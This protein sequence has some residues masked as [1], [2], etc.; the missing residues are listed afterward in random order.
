MLTRRLTALAIVA[1]FMVHIA[2]V[3]PAAEWLNRQASTEDN[4]GLEIRPAP[5]EMI[6]PLA[7]WLLPDN[8][9]H[10]LEEANDDARK[11]ES[12]LGFVRTTQNQESLV[13]PTNPSFLSD[14]NT[15]L[16]SPD[17][18][19]EDP[20]ELP[21]VD[22]DEEDTTDLERRSF[23]DGPVLEESPSPINPEPRPKTMPPT[24]V[25]QRP[26]PEQTEAKETGT[27]SQPLLELAQAIPLPQPQPGGNLG[28]PNEL[29]EYPANAQDQPGE[30]KQET[31]LPADPSE[32]MPTAQEGPQTPAHPLTPPPAPSTVPM[33]DRNVPAFQSETYR[34]KL[35]GFAKETGDA[36]FDAKNTPVGR[37]YKKIG[38]A[39]ERKWQRNIT[40]N[41]DFHAFAKIRVKFTVNQWGKARNVEILQDKGNAV[42]TN[43]TV[44]AILEADIPKMPSSVVEMLDHG[45]LQCFFNFSIR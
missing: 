32:S 21:N 36:A 42:L 18:S 26:T 20:T 7:E 12:K 3:P 11:R 15:R 37:Y 31:Q 22:G 35:T 2:L 43:Q 41:H 27:P 33:P 34:A 40:N 38:V 29:I 8:A 16:Q 10:T 4:E 24:V 17:P 30:P 6:L 23:R 19:T 9:E 25:S 5:V 44:A 39:V 45:E 1:S 14:R 13:A 28:L